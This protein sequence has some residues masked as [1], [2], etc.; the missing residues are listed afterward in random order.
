M[1]VS[2]RVEE[3]IAQLDETQWTEEQAFTHAL[4]EVI[5]E[6]EGRTW[7]AGQ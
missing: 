6:D 3:K 5:A 7:A 1:W 4:D 2:A